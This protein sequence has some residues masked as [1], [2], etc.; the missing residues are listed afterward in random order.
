MKDFG[1]NPDPYTGNPKGS[2]YT[3][4]LHEINFL[5]D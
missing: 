5:T 1:P 4:S 2:L 3:M